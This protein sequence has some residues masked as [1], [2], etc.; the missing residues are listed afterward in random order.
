MKIEMRDL[1]QLVFEVGYELFQDDE[2]GYMEPLF[3]I[4]C[5]KEQVTLK[6]NKANLT[7]LINGMIYLR[8]NL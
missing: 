7:K 5:P 2:T 3:W 4:D 6:M 8:D 1:D